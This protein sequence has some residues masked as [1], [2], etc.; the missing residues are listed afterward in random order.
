MK[1]I[2][3]I[4]LAAVTLAGTSAFGQ[5][6]F[7][8]QT[9]KS[10]AYDG[11]TTPGASAAGATVTVAF[12]WAASG[13]TVSLPLT[14]TPITGNSLTVESYTDAQAWTAILGSGFTPAVN[15]N[16]STAAVQLTAANGS[17]SYNG[18]TSFGVQGTATSASATPYALY[19][20]GWGGGYST[21]AAAAA[22]HAPVGWSSV[23]TYTAGAN[24][25]SS[26]A[27]FAAASPNFGVFFPVVPEPTTLALAALGGA[28]LLLFRRKK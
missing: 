9:G 18:G 26:I 16:G 22:A 13:S 19:L 23:F 11:F 4:S 21:L 20:V 8:F 6:Y 1:K 15:A 14:S 28:S 2:I 17:V 25:S 7:Q 27:N 3:A 12:L 24:A 10:Q 5:G